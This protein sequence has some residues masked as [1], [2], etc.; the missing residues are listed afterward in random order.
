MILSIIIPVYNV[1][2]YL[3]Y[4][5]DSI[6]VQSFS[7]YEIILINDGSKDNSKNICIKYAEKYKNIKLIN[8][9]NAG[10]S[11]AR[12]VGIK[13]SKGKYL[14][15][16]DSDDFLV[17]D[18]T[19]NNIISAIKKYE[20]DLLMFSIIE[21]DD[22]GKKIIKNNNKFV[23]FEYQT[24]KGKDIFDE[25]YMYNGIYVSMAPNKVIRKKF[26]TNNNLHFVK[27]I[28]HE[29]DEWLSRVLI[30]YPSI[31]FCN[32]AFYG[33]RHREKS[34]ITDT[35]K[36]IL[37]KRNLDK[38][39]IGKSMLNNIRNNKHVFYISYSLNYLLNALNN[40]YLLE[41]NKNVFF[42]KLLM[43]K[44]TLNKLKYSNKSFHK[45]LYITNRI[46]GVKFMWKTYLILTKK[47][48]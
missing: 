23:Y 38:I 22:T 11:E 30:N 7:D 41:K 10:L 32:S 46:F 17:K 39:Q 35:N 12:N 44:N 19:L 8:Q 24:Y 14:L 45:I 3:S 4:C 42:D 6:L 31:Y 18:N 34:I 13:N 21:Y 28:Y 37:I 26:L 15:F 36:N 9:E 25:L 40:Y 1:E 2:N 48:K 33:Y 29:D 20:P 47:D 16:I 27:G 5:L 43:I